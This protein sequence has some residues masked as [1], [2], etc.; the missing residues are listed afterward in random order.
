[1]EPTNNTICN[2]CN[3]I[4]EG[5]ILHGHWQCGECKAWNDEGIPNRCRV[6]NKETN[7]VFN[8]N[9]K[10]VAVCESCANKI[11]MQNVSSLVK[12]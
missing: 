8:I 9:F 6:C 2:N 4:I 12:K 5:V 1:M 10:A 3:H 7:V 11:T